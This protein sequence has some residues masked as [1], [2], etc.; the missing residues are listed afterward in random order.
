M[1][2]KC[3]KCG[4][5]DRRKIKEF[6]DKNQKPLYFSMQGTPVFPKRLKC[7]LCGEE[8]AAPKQD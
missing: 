5:A 3:P 7:G 6:D 2:N 8:W 1:A 4:N